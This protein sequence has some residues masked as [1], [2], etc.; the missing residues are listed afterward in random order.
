MSAMSRRTL[1]LVPLLASACQTWRTVPLA[2]R[3]SGSL[4]AQVRVV[5]MGGEAVDLDAAR[6]SPDSVVGMGGRGRVAIPRD[7]V[8]FVQQPQIS[9]A[10][11]LGLIVGVPLAALG[12]LFLLAAAA[13]AE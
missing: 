10:R 8:A 3:D 13:Y 4:P 6:V 2:P 5:R 9:S 1:V 12:A 7:S 11:T